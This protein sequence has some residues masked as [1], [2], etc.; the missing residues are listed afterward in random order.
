MRALCIDSAVDVTADD[1]RTAIVVA[2]TGISEG[3]NMAIAPDDVSELDS[4]EQ[5]SDQCG[6]ALDQFLLAAKR[7]PLL[8]PAE[9]TTH[10]HR[11][12]VEHCAR[13]GCIAQLTSCVG[14]AIE[15]ARTHR[16]S[17]SKL[18]NCV[19]TVGD[20]SPEAKQRSF[21]AGLASRVGGKVQFPDL[22]VTA[23][24]SRLGAALDL[25]DRAYGAVRALPAPARAS[26]EREHAE[27]ARLFVTFEWRWTVLSEM[28]RRFEVAA[29][30]CLGAKR[31]LMAAALGPRAAERDI[32]MLV[33]RVGVDSGN[34]QEFTAAVRHAG[35]VVSDD[36]AVA[37]AFEVVRA[38]EQIHGRSLERVL[39]L[40]GQYEAARRRQSAAANEIVQRN[41]RLVAHRVA[42]LG[43]R[44]DAALDA[45][46]EG[47]EGLMEAAYRF[48]YWYG[49]R[50]TTYAAFWITE[51]L[52]LHHAA[53]ASR[54]VRIPT[55]VV[56]T[57]EAAR[58]ARKRLAAQLGREATDAEVARD[59]RIDRATLNEATNAYQRPQSYDDE[60]HLQHDAEDAVFADAARRD[61]KRLVARAVAELPATMRSVAELR[62]GLTRDEPMTLSEISSRMRLSVERC[63]SIETLVLRRLRSRMP[64]RERADFLDA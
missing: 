20:Q 47:N 29:K 4:A 2:A 5:P 52:Q 8:T 3:D 40:H 57:R 19:L 12:Y 17:S 59:L 24:V 14:Y 13:V 50:F 56:D 49:L 58:R 15:L 16:R 26:A 25:L 55:T 39:A 54:A 35:V 31:A 9:V 23:D 61:L 37:E 7:M 34:P 48:K 22:S 51:R 63:R 42:G 1:N 32:E 43:L 21:E 28:Q 64:F 11:V 44:G 53:G 36:P 60:L 30:E 27:L 10:A 6:S 41:L 33:A 45:I 18:T 62:F 46:Q 38:L